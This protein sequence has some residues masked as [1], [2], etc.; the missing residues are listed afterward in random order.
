MSE[1]FFSN[2]KKEEKFHIYKE[3]ELLNEE[4]SEYKII[5]I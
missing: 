3:R 1:S 2:Q 4:N 5:K